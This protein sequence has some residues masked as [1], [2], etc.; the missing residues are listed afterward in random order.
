MNCFHQHKKNNKKRT[1]REEYKKQ[2]KQKERKIK[3]ETQSIGGL[4]KEIYLI[5]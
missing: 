1:Q 5:K 3:I 4:K 2:N